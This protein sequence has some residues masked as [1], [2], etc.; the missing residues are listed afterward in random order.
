M[1]E[2]LNYF[3]EKKYDTAGTTQD[4]VNTYEQRRGDAREQ[5]EALGI[6]KKFISTGGLWS[7]A[8]FPAPNSY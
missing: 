8:R 6:A 3:C 1:L 2:K 5:V 7:N 4:I